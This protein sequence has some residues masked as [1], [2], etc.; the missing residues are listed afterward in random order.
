MKFSL[1]MVDPFCSELPIWHPKRLSMKLY[2]AWKERL[3]RSC[4]ESTELPLLVLDG[5]EP[6]SIDEGSGETAVT[7]LQMAYLLHAVGL[8]EGL[9]ESVIVELGA[10]RGV[11]T[12]LLAQA[13]S[14][15]VIAV[16]RYLPRWAEAEDALRAFNVRT[17]DL[18][19]VSLCQ[20]A[21]GQ[22]ASDWS[23]GS[24]GMLFVDAQHNY[25]N[26]RFDVQVWEPHLL[27]GAIVALHDVDRVHFAGTRVAAFELQDRYE[28]VAHVDNLALF[29]KPA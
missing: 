15:K 6:I 3:A 20:S 16:D 4:F 1:A 9:S 21:S 12:R 25:V 17:Q 5:V 13:T 29:R 18:P 2:V 27:A 14:R 26:T 23:H 11:T 22:A 10:Y 28:L 19:N 24:V 7:P 8:S